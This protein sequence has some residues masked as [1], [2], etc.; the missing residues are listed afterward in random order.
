ME[1]VLTLAALS[2]AGAFG[3]G[4]WLGRTQVRAQPPQNLEPTYNTPDRVRD[5]NARMSGKFIP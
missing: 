3:T 1:A 5:F 2:V 4:Y